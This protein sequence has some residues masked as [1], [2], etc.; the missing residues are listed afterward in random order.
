[1]KKKLKII[2]LHRF[3]YSSMNTA[4]KKLTWI[5][6]ENKKLKKK[7]LKELKTLQ[8]CET[9][10]TSEALLSLLAGHKVYL[11]PGHM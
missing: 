4:K 2:K 9:M 8:V 10:H 6:K 5:S 1:M 7:T 11:F 3:K